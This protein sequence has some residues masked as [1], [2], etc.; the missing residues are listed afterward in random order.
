[1]VEG[2]FEKL[3]LSNIDKLGL[4]NHPVGELTDSFGVNQ[5]ELEQ[6]FL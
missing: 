3:G 2:Y 5:F 4:C 6:G 1:M